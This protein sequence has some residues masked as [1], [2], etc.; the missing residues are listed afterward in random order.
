MHNILYYFIFKYA[1][2]N[3]LERLRNNYIPLFSWTNQ[4]FI[5]YI[6]YIPTVETWNYKTFAAGAISLKSTLLL[7]MAGIYS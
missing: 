2:Y 3:H 7:D 1:Y 6:W 4:L 5:M